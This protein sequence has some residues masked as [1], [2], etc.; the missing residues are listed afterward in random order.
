LTISG[1]EQFSLSKICLQFTGERE[2]G[3]IN[4]LPL[5]IFGGNVT[6][7]TRFDVKGLAVKAGE[8]TAKSLGTQAG[9][10]VLARIAS[11]TVAELG[12]AAFGIFA[13]A[14][15][16]SL[17]TALL[18][19]EDKIKQQL[20]LQ[21]EEPFLTGC[22]VAQ[23]ALLLPARNDKE[24]EYREERLADARRSLDRAM[25]FASGKGGD[26]DTALMTQLVLGLCALEI[27]GGLHEAKTRFTVVR[28]RLAEDV[29]KLQQLHDR[30]T[31]ELKTLSLTKEGYQRDLRH[32]R[33]ASANTATLL[34]LLKKAESAL[35]AKELV[36]HESSDRLKDVKTVLA[37]AEEVLRH[38]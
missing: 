20:K 29:P 34:G 30:H 6:F 19:I 4:I 33:P 3:Q 1:V 24:K 2:C 23:D 21:I 14:L 36:F 16:K 17:L 27:E 38:Q 5:S 25:T 31:S 32:E 26:A 15:A 11:G 22:R 12:A 35:K 10:D 8:D 9:K 28:D 13:G 37:L 18:Q 7:L